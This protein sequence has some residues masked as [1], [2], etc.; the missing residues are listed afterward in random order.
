MS[1]LKSHLW[2]WVQIPLSPLWSV[3]LVGLGHFPFTEEIT[4]SNPVRTTI[5][6]G[7]YIYSKFFVMGRKMGYIVDDSG[8]SFFITDSEK[9]DRLPAGCYSVEQDAAGTV[10]I[11]TLNPDFNSIITLP[12]SPLPKLS[13]EVN[14]FWTEADKYSK[15]SLQHKRGILLHGMPGSG[16]TSVVLKLCEDSIKHDSLIFFCNFFDDIV[17][18]QLQRVR[19]IEP[20]RPLVIVLEELE[21]SIIDESNLINVDLLN[22]IDGTVDINHVLFIASTTSLDFIPD[23]I[24]KR[25]SRFDLKVQINLPDA[26]DREYYLKTL[27]PD[28]DLKKINLDTWIKNTEGYTISHLKELI[29]SYFIYGTPYKTAISDINKLLKN[30]REIGFSNNQ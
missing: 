23:T 5:I 2:T 30:E 26:T 19:Q 11:K 20:D 8:N 29:T 25:P 3:R 27:I 28:S 7:Y 16:K 6:L 21:V 22:F 15:F 4:G 13:E 14:K 10:F 9:V 17:K 24:K 12:N 1:V 18:G